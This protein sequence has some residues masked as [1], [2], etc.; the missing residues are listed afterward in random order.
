MTHPHHD[1]TDGHQCC[2]GKAKL[3]CPEERCHDHIASGFE[4]AI[5]LH[6]NAAA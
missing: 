5:R 3:L 1:A 6:R 4:L 2:R